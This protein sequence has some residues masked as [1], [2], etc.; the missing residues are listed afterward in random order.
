MR[1]SGLRRK[2]KPMALG[3]AIS[4]KSSGEL[5]PRYSRYPRSDSPG[6]LP[7]QISSVWNAVS[8]KAVT[9][10]P[11]VFGIWWKT[12]VSCESMGRSFGLTNFDA[13]TG[14]SSLFVELKLRLLHAACAHRE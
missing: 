8:R 10:V 2:V 5:C 3:P 7:V 11:A 13:P 14:R 4:S 12:T 9:V 1:V 6:R